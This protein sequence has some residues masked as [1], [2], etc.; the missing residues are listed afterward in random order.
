[1]AKVST[2]STA[3]L[4]VILIVIV[5]AGLVGVGGMVMQRSISEYDRPPR[6]TRPGTRLPSLNRLLESPEG[7]WALPVRASRNFSTGRHHVK[8]YTPDL[9]VLLLEADVMDSR[10]LS[11][12]WITSNEF[13][14]DIIDENG[15]VVGRNVQIP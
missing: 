10:N 7:E 1:M 5:V 4:T 2:T 15:S 13:R 11:V 8:I 3:L 9:S 12:E 6:Q 14:I